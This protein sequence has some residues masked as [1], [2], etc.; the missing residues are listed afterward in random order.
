MEGLTPAQL[1]MS[2][3]TSRGRVSQSPIRRKS[4]VITGS[5]FSQAERGVQARVRHHE[6]GE[7]AGA[8][9]LLPGEGIPS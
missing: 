8:L 4:G 3:A 5:I 6:G 9:P 1:S 7:G 2:W